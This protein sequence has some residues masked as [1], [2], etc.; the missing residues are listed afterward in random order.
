MTEFVSQSKQTANFNDDHVVFTLIKSRAQL[1]QERL[2]REHERMGIVQRPVSA[3]ESESEGKKPNKASNNKPK[4]E[5]KLVDDIDN[6]F[7]MDSES[8]FND[9]DLFC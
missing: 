9:D 1:A 7:T 5:D 8:K 2:K 6:F 3:P 4:K